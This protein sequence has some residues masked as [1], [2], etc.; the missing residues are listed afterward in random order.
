[1]IKDFVHIIKNDY[2]LIFWIYGYIYFYT[3]S[4]HIGDLGGLIF[5]IINKMNNFGYKY[6][7]FLMVSQGKFTSTMLLNQGTRTLK[8]QILF[9]DVIAFDIST[10][11][12]MISFLLQILHT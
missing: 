1:M 4:S 9:G 8:Y 12:V 5:F 10:P 2:Y 6:F 3:H 11:G 7:V